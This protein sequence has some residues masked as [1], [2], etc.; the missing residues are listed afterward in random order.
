MWQRR[1]YTITLI[2]VPLVVVLF[3]V[4]SVSDTNAKQAQPADTWSTF[5]MIYSESRYGLGFNGDYGTQRIK[6]TYDDAY[7]WRVDLL[8]HSAM[9][10]IVGS[11]SIYNGTEL[12]SFD[13]RV[14]HEMVTDVSQDSSIYLAAEWLRPSYIR[15]LLLKD[16]ARLLPSSIEGQQVMEISEEIQCSQPVEIEEQAGLKPCDSTNKRQ[17]T[18]QI[19]YLEQEDIPLRIVDTMDGI[20][21]QEIVVEEL[22]FK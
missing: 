12:Q 1:I 2:L 15:F 16:N 17:T 19:T 18:R 14:G 13:P 9:P 7:H 22:N 8:S 11:W 10:E 6:F 20:V 3:F 21:V 4:F 5:E